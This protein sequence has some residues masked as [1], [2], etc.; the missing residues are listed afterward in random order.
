M[1]QIISIKSGKDTT[2]NKLL[3][4][5]PV[6][7]PKYTFLVAPPADS[8]AHAL[9]ETLAARDKYLGIMDFEEPLRRATLEMYWGSLTPDVNMDTKN[10][11]TATLPVAGGVIET[12]LT[13]FAGLVRR[14][15]GADILARLAVNAVEESYYVGFDRFVFRDATTIEVE[16]FVRSFGTAKCLTVFFC[17]A[18]HMKAKVS[19]FPC[20]SVVLN[21][22]KVDEQIA[23]LE[24]E[25]ECL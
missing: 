2:V 18:D 9:A 1:I 3:E 15:Y 12:W 8:K 19:N 24:T 5:R 16:E 6:A 14:S 10:L 11:R 4:K 20:R 7:L 17:I 13:A 22:G 25:L 21:S 23:Q